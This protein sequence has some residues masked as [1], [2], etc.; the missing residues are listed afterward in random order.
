M[1]ETSTCNYDY[2]LF[3]LTRTGKSLEIR[4]YLKKIYIRYSPAGRSVLRET[5]PEGTVSLNTDRPRPVNNILFFSYRDLKVSGNF[6]SAPN[7][8]VLKKG[9]FALMLLKARDRLQTKTKH[10]NMI[11]NL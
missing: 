3:V 4:D 9:A 7:L 8:C 10:C 1:L 2:F 5:V 6:T 11:F